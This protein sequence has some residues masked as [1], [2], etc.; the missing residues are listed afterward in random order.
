MNYR[1]KAINDLVQEFKK[2]HDYKPSIEQ[3]LKAMPDM[4][5]FA[6]Y[7]TIFGKTVGEEKEAA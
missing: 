2:E 7:L 6:L 1:T 4:N 5:L 3:A